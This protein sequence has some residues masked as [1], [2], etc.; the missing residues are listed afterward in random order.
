MSGLSVKQMGPGLGGGGASGKRGVKEV[1]E[2]P[3]TRARRSE[4]FPKHNRLHLCHTDPQHV[5]QPT[6]PLLVR[7]STRAHRNQTL[8]PKPAHSIVSRP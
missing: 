2:D 8:L 1:Q 4:L 3:N 6:T 5:L 7:D